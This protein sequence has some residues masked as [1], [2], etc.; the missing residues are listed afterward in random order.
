MPRNMSL[1]PVPFSLRNLLQ[2]LL[3][4]HNDRSRDPFT[5]VNVSV[6]EHA[7]PLLFNLGK[8]ISETN[9]NPEVLEALICEF[10]VAAR[11]MTEE[12]PE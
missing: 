8:E 6:E 9:N 11:S 5:F 1:Q 10:Y 2:D 3:A 7:P 12:G 4:N